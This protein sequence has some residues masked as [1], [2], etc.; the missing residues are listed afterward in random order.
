VRLSLLSGLYAIGSPNSA[1]MTISNQYAAAVNTWTGGGVNS[2]ASNPTNWSLGHAP[3][4]TDVIILDATTNKPMTWDAAA[5]RTIGGW[6]QGAAYTGVVTFATVFG[7]NGFTNLTIAGSVALNGGTW[8][9]R[10]MSP[11]RRTG[12]T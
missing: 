6:D 7:T 5:V 4:T 12:C 8:T 3:Q 11:R 9:T 1:T 2:L 10:I